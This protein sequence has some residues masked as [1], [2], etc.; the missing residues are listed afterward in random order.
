MAINFLGGKPR[1]GKSY[2]AVDFLINDLRFT[3]KNPVTNLALDLD[4]IQ[5]LMNEEGRDVDVFARVT[6]LDTEQVSEFFRYRGS[7]LVLDYNYTG[8][9]DK[10]G[11]PVIDPKEPIDIGPTL[12]HPVCAQ[13]VVYYL[14]ELHIYFNSRKWKETG[15]VTL[16]YLSQH[17]KLGDDVWC[18]T[19]SIANVDKQFRSVAQEFHYVRNFSKEKF[20]I[21][22]MGDH[23]EERVFMQPASGNDT[24]STIE[25]FTLNKKVA[26]CYHTSGGVGVPAGGV[27]DIGRKAKGIPIWSLWV[28]LVLGVGAIWWSS[29]FIPRL[30]EGGLNMAQNTG[31]KL[32]P[33]A[34]VPAPAAMPP[35]PVSDALPSQSLAVNQP[36]ASR[37]GGVTVTGF[38]GSR[39]RGRVTVYLS[40]GRVYDEQA[41]SQI[42]IDR[43]GAVIDGERFFYARPPASISVQTLPAYTPQERSKTV[44]EAPSVPVTGSWRTDADGVQRLTDAAVSQS[45][46]IGISK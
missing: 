35:V 5:H 9:V 29:K 21:F 28:V 3:K 45:R 27:A 7:G 19:Q 38:V 20:G 41:G 39:I 16:W 15:D 11:K 31:S 24:P 8:K 1:G 14:D 4:E 46:A 25:K 6:L 36:S 40:D 17:A 23:F 34:P 43:L 30:L 37:V 42:T 10:D 22:K 12:K 33:T 32:V 44:N 18:I 13:G 2:R 26:K